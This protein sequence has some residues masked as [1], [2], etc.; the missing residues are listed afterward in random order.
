MA[1]SKGRRKALEEKALEEAGKIVKNQICLS[2]IASG[3]PRIGWSWRL[4]CFGLGTPEL[5]STSVT[6]HAASAISPEATAINL[7]DTI[8]PKKVTFFFLGHGSESVFLLL[9]ERSSE[10]LLGRGSF[11]VVDST[12]V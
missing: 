10:Y 12:I 6:M 7:V 5:A 3:L 11:F 9:S 8:P 2:F 4:K 1:Y